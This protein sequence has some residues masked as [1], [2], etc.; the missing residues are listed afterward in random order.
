VTDPRMELVGRG[1]D[2]I[3]ERFTEW[4][5]R[6]VGD[7]RRGWE[8]ELVSRLQ[9]GVRLLELGCGAGVPD[10]QRLAARFRLTGIDVSAEQVRRARAAVPDAEFIHADFTALELALCVQSRTARVARAHV[11]EDSPLARAAWATDDRAWNERHGGL[12]R[13]LARCTD[14]LL[15][16]PARNEHPARERGR[17]RDP[18]RRARHL[19]RARRRRD[20]PVGT[21][22]EMSLRGRVDALGAARLACASVHE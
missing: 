15:E 5:D 19:P 12:D 6:I 20:L 11:R 7:P 16:L 1:Y 9:D 10:T 8:D 3:G 14:V 17:L 18:S 2:T 22:D 21:R 13:G 4:R